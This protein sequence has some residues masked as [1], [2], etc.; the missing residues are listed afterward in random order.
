M[1]KRNKRDNDG[2]Q[3]VVT[4]E[5]AAPSPETEVEAAAPEEK[6]PEKKEPEV[7]E[8]SVQLRTFVTTSAHKWD[9]MH[10]FEGHAKRNKL[11]PMPMKQWQEAYEKF[12]NRPL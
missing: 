6:A 4:E 8:N 3:P 2:E 5:A 11:G 9:Q 10:P 7:L 12:L 1:A